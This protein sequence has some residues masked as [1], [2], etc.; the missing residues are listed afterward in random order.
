MR[1]R[2]CFI[3]SCYLLYYRLVWLVVCFISIA[4]FALAQTQP[5]LSIAL[6]TKNGRLAIENSRLDTAAYTY[7]PAVQNQ[8]LE[9]IDTVFVLL[10]SAMQ[11]EDRLCFFCKKDIAGKKKVFEEK[12]VKTYR[13]ITATDQSGLELVENFPINPRRE[14]L[15]SLDRF[16][17][18]IF[19]N[20]NRHW[21][22]GKPLRL[23]QLSSDVFESLVLDVLDG[24]LEDFELEFELQPPINLE[25]FHILWEGKDTLRN[26]QKRQILKDLDGKLWY[27]EQIKER[28]IRYYDLL[29]YTLSLDIGSKTAKIYPAKIV[30]IATS[31]SA[32]GK[33]YKRKVSC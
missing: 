10:D 26:R 7:S 13:W 14:G 4:L 8:L 1:K 6:A 25:N 27:E 19:N 33:S 16:L 28:I 23:K 24:V 20:F 30:Y 17:F 21:W 12:F 22:Q 2:P 18:V 31:R 29:N 11:R 15:L 9:E 3:V 5:T 32:K